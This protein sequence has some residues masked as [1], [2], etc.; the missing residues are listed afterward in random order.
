[1]HI[2]GESLEA[3]RARA[4]KVRLVVFDLDGVLTDGSLILGEGG[5]DLKVFNTRDGQGLAMLRGSG[6]QIAVISGRSSFAVEQRMKELGIE[7]VY[8]G[9]SDKLSTFQIL[10]RKLKL[11]PS[12]AAYVGDDLPDLPVMM[13]VG[14]A[15][16]VADAHELV[17]EHAHWQTRKPGGRGAA[18]EVSDLVMDAQGLLAKYYARHLGLKK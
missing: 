8:Q 16:A 7:Y 4:A 18:R 15:V 3:V 5:E 12:E 17:R 13:R 9:A 14:L 10:L 6:I 11:D 1:M 2:S